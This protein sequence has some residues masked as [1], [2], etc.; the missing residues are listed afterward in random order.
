MRKQDERLPVANWRPIAI[1][2]IGDAYTESDRRAPVSRASVNI[3]EAIA[4]DRDECLSLNDFRRIA[5]QCNN[6]TRH[7]S[8]LSAS[9]Q[10]LYV[11]SNSL[12][13]GARRF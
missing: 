8:A 5:T 7:Y 11:D 4:Y 12:D 9:R 10:L 6:L 1:L 13:T 3:C 2:L